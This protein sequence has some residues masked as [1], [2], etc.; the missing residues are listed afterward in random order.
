M[1]GV[2]AEK[3]NKFEKIK[4]FIICHSIISVCLVWTI[5]TWH[6]HSL[7]RAV[8]LH[9]FEIVEFFSTRKRNLIE[10]N[11]YR[12]CTLNITVSKW[13]VNSNWWQCC[14][15]MPY[16]YRKFVLSTNGKFN[17][18]AVNLRTFCLFFS[19]KMEKIRM[20]IT[21]YKYSY[22]RKDWLIREQ[23][24]I[25]KF[26]FRIESPRIIHT[27]LHINNDLNDQWHKGD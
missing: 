22:R 3:C 2:K 13:T 27:E 6:H 16:L 17:D 23:L 4:I 15:S 20:N 7:E 18:N 10:L 26:S 14:D 5:F 12:V 19:M 1:N 21:N 24:L 25:M 8:T 11:I 9:H